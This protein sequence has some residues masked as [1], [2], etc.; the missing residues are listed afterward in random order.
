MPKQITRGPLL[1]IAS[2]LMMLLVNRLWRFALVL[3]AIGGEAS[4][5]LWPLVL[6][7]AALGTDAMSLSIGIGLRGVSRGDIARVS[8]VVGVFHVLMPLLGLGLG[9]IPGLLLGAYARWL[10][11][12][13]VAWIGLRMIRGCLGTRECQAANWVITGLPLLLL[14]ASVSLDALSVGFSLGVF[15]YSVLVSALVFGL[16]GALLTALGLL[17][18]GNLGHWLGNRAELFGGGVLIILALHMFLEG[19]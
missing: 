1:V 5:Q 12:A 8:F 10:G 14:A 16:F 2:V 11:A 3:E 9:Q 15:G 17:F 19:R 18:G 13:V 4:H 6:M 7:G